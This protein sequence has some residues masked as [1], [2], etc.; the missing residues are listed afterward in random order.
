[1][2]SVRPIARNTNAYGQIKKV[3]PACIKSVFVPKLRT[4]LDVFFK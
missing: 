3:S 2:S 4:L 1:M